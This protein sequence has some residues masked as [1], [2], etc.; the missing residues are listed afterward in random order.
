MGPD[1]RKETRE[2]IARVERALAAIRAGEMVILTDD[3]DRENEGDLVMA[4]EKVTPQAINF[5]ATHGRGLICL[6]VTR[7]KARQLDLP[8]MVQH[9]ESP[10]HT[11]FTVSIEAARGV[12]TGISAKDRATTIRAAANPKA[13]AGDLVRPGHIFPLI[14]C[15]G[16]VLVRTGQ[17]EG[18]VDLSRLAGLN[19]S[20]V[21]CEIM[22]PDGTM[23][24]RP[25]LVRFARR[26]KLVL[27]SVADLIRYRLERE[28]QVERVESRKLPFGSLGE[29]EVVRYRSAVDQ[30]EHLA[31]LRGDLEG[32]APPLVRVHSACPLG[33]AFGFSGCDCGLQLRR[34]LELIAREGRGAV[35]YLRKDPPIALGCAQAAADC[36]DG[37]ERRLREYGL[38][39]QILRDLGIG[40]LRLLTNNPKK[41]VGVEGYGLTVTERVSIEVEPTPENRAYLRRKRAAGQLAVRAAAKRRS[42]KSR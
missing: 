23:A 28:G 39:A 21:L 15:D 10:F 29:F 33:D 8:L 26:H 17:T 24:R 32:G 36:S 22:N 14:A 40:R 41:I 37:S 38:G 34:S 4:A 20:G 42:S 19:H 12:S 13:V 5:M 31:L 30:R 16:G 3:E 27:L 2:S 35:V 6:T 9:N 1:L 18:S 11:A 25:E 7:E